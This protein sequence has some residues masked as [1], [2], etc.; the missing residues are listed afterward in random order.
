MA[1]HAEALAGHGHRL[2][3][4]TESSSGDSVKV[5]VRWLDGERVRRFQW[6]ALALAL[7]VVL[8]LLHRRCGGRRFSLVLTAALLLWQPYWLLSLSFWLSVS[9]LA[10]VFLLAWRYPPLSIN[11]LPTLGWWQGL[12]WPFL[13]YQ[14]LFS[15]LMLPLQVKKY[16]KF[17][18]ETKLLT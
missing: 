3:L 1:R 9:A 4:Q 5:R 6:V 16:L 12:V 15:L 17:M 11:P 8:K 10:L 14:L 18:K 13:R 7:L 2:E